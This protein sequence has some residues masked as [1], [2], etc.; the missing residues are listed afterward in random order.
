MHAQP[1]RATAFALA[2]LML[3]LL[4]LLVALPHGRMAPVG[5]MRFDPATGE[6]AFVRDEGA[7]AV[8]GLANAA[9]GLAVLLTLASLALPYL[10]RL[11]LRRLHARVG[12]IILVLAA[13]HTLLF[14][15]EGSF[16]GWLPGALSLLAFGLHGATGALRARLARAWGPR[17]WRFAHHASAWAALALVAEH[18][19]LASWHFGLARWFAA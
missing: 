4:A 10:R 8:R 7:M 11:S 9:G 5:E 16:R 6:H 1:T 2:F 13:L 15:R 14:L 17:W 19:L 3:G 18:V 12:V